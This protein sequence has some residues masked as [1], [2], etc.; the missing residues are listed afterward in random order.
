MQIENS[1]N[2]EKLSDTAQK[3]LSTIREANKMEVV[4]VIACALTAQYVINT[5]LLDRLRA[6]P[7]PFVA[8]LSRFYDVK[9]KASGKAWLL[10]DELHNKYGKVVRTGYNTVSIRDLD[11]VKQIYGNERFRKSSFYDAF[12]FNGAHNMFATTVPTDHARYRR[13]LAPGFSQATL[14]G[15]EDVI[16][17]SGILALMDKFDTK[18]ANQHVVCNLFDEFHLLAFD[19]LGEMAYGKSFD[20]IKLQSHPFADWLKTRTKQMPVTT[21]FPGINRY[22]RLLGLLFPRAA[23]ATENIF[24]FSK[25]SMED[26]LADKD[27]TRRDFTALMLAALDSDKK[28]NYLTVPESQVASVMLIVAGTDTTSNSMTFIAFLLG[29][30]PKVKE[31]LFQELVQAMPDK[32]ST[33]RY[34]DAR[35]DQLPYLWAVMMEATRLYP[36]VPGG[37]PRVT[38]KGGEIIGGQ[39]IPEGTIVEVPAWSIQHDASIFEEPFE[40]KPE[41]WLADDSEELAKHHLLFSY[42]P[43]MCAGKK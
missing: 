41:R 9:L 23:K 6:I 39:F 15:L 4:G 37:L 14:D 5:F 16:M 7:G 18:F 20:M 24:D 19:I 22:P 40:F 26:R 3:L 28:S 13:I 33:L 25:K 31:R 42:G 12:V 30:H 11:A 43:R 10:I 34:K 36:A 38:P 1:F 29:K 21:T 17:D 8:K 32:N 27:N 2:L 35:K